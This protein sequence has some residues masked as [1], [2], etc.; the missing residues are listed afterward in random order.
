[1]DQEE[2]YLIFQCPHCD[3]LIIIMKDDLNCCIFRHAVYKDSFFQVDPH[4]SEQLCNYLRRSE[5]VFGCAKPFRIIQ[6]GHE[7]DAV[8]CAYI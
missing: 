7:Y 8:V 3:E 5:L 6:I 4:L 1:M 2:L